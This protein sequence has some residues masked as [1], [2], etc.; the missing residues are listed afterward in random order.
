[1]S[2]FGESDSGDNF[3][4]V[5]VDVLS[6]SA[7]P[8]N[9]IPPAQ[10]EEIAA[11]A[12]VRAHQDNTHRSQLLTWTMW[13][14]PWVLMINFGVFVLYMG[15]Q[16]GNISASVMIAWISATVV[17]VLGIAYIIASDLF[18]DGSPRRK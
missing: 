8:T 9:E 6:Q 5:G 4:D 10:A 3:D 18:R 12:A 7:A 16:W 15:S 13:L 17:E 1:M 2:S 14:V 11:A